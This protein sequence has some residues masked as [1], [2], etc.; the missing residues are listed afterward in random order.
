MRIRNDLKHAKWNQNVWEMTWIFICTLFV[1]QMCDNEKKI[2]TSSLIWIKIWND[3][4]KTNGVMIIYL[5]LNYKCLNR[6]KN[7]LE[8]QPAHFEKKVHPVEDWKQIFL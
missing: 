4:T 6:K 1:L 3:K 5:K 8:Y 2:N 7:L